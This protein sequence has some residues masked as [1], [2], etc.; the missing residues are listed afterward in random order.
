VL[1]GN[2]ARTLHPVAGQGLNLALRDVAE[3]AG[4]LRGAPD[5][6]CAALLEKFAVRRRADQRG[7]TAM[8][9]LLVKTFSSGFAPLVVARN[10]GLIAMDLL[11]PLRHWFARRSMGLGAR[12]PMTGLG[13]AP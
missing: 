10:A 8:T 9:D 13:G 1:I 7:T 6:G 11:P 5:P 3:L 4:L 12:S 2:A